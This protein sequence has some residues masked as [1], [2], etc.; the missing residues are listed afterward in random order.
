MTPSRRRPGP[1]PTNRLAPLALAVAAACAACPPAGAATYTWD[2]DGP[3]DRWSALEPSG[4]SNWTGSGPLGLPHAGEAHRFVFT[5]VRRLAPD[6]D[7]AG[8]RSAGLSFA[9]GAGPFTLRGLA[10]TS[11]G[12]I[13]NA[14][15]F[16]QTIEMPLVADGDQVWDG[17]TAGLRIVSTPTVAGGRLTLR[18]VE[19][20][21]GP[22]PLALQAGSVRAE[23]GAVVVTSQTRIDKDASLVATA[24]A[25]WR[26][27]TVFDQV[28]GTA[29]FSA[30]ARLEA[31]ALDLGT[32]GKSTTLT[33]EGAGTAGHIGGRATLG[34]MAGL[35]V[36]QGARLDLVELRAGTTD[37][38]GMPP[39]IRVEGQGSELKVGSMT[40]G[41]G[42]PIYPGNRF[43]MAVLDG[44]SVEGG[45]L[46]AGMQGGEAGGVRV[47]GAG[48]TWRSVGTELGRY[49]NG[50][51][52][53][54]A[55]ARG[56]TSTLSLGR[57]GG[58]Q[59]ALTVTGAGS[60]L[61]TAG[62]LGNLAGSASVTV[63][64]GAELLTTGFYLG[65]SAQASLTVS[66]GATLRAPYLEL[67]GTR[68]TADV[69][70]GGSVRVDYTASFS[71][72]ALTLD[73]GRLHAEQ[74]MT[75]TGVALALRG[76]GRLSSAQSMVLDGGTVA[77]AGTAVLT[78]PWSL[79]LGDTAPTIVTMAG[80]RIETRDLTLSGPAGTT[81][82][83]TAGE[84]RAST[85]TLGAGTTL[86][87]SGG[88]LAVDGLLRLGYSGPATLNTRGGVVSF[89]SEVQVGPQGLVEV[90]L[91]TMPGTIR[92]AG[93]TW[94]GGLMT[95]HLIGHGSFVGALSTQAGVQ[96]VAHQ[97]TLV[98]GN[99]NGS[100]SVVIGGD[101]TVGGGATLELRDLQR[102]RMGGT[103]T[104]TEGATLRANTSGHAGH[105][106]GE[107]ELADTLV[108]SV[109]GSARIDAQVLGGG[110]FRLVDANPS[111]R[112][113]FAG[114][115]LGNPRFDGRGE[116]VVE[117]L[118]DPGGAGQAVTGDFGNGTVDLRYGDGAHLVLDL[119]QPAA[120]DRL[121]DIG[122]LT[123]GGTLALRFGD[124]DG[125]AGGAVVDLLDFGA[126]GG[127]FAAYEVA[128]LDRNRLD[129]S[130]L[131]LDGT[132]TVSAVPEPG[133]WA[134]WLAG[135]AAVG[136]LAQRRAPGLPGARRP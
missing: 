127:G 35:V 19:L 23:A 94:M 34:S 93:G 47:A 44:G 64:D 38:L 107:L 48:S 118:H 40:I 25:Q 136:R 69:R 15:P 20:V 133:T 130:R 95:G 66:G 123:A 8:L 121:V 9:A 125:W 31:E 112:L 122:T 50:T 92:L 28:G 77:L 16:L 65:G 79:A 3:N 87:Q 74:A 62:L 99:P 89:G 53:I 126:F 55:G 46:I 57:Y 13:V 30:G 18:R 73:G 58:A 10:L 14:S 32:T 124:A 36:R 4:R 97:G 43:E 27:A 63:A 51:L 101:T 119:L 102:A 81:V 42:Q 90:G 70:S 41:M 12:D 2:G 37:M 49:G 132:V 106:W 76:D 7:I 54:E 100:P 135:L 11:Q 52:S 83:I 26:S 110:L 91:P 98:V 96:L 6:N 129:F 103:L 1:P 128:G 29:T 104:L 59:G 134:L 39:G 45:N 85:L 84:L 78:A 72:L 33:F 61:D 86:R 24:G 60:F 22:L 68:T 111:A 80:G 108:A 114:E 5:G 82:D 113:V 71:D 67:R 131:A 21:P 120:F 17:G 105:G 75:F 56:L 109:R 115:L 88:T 117:G 116:V